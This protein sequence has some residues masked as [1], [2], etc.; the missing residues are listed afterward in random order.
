MKKSEPSTYLRTLFDSVILIDIVNRY[1]IRNSVALTNLAQLLI[2]SVA[3]RFTSRSLE[4]SLNN[5]ISFLTIQKYLTHLHEAYLLFELQAFSF[6]T[7]QRIASE[8][9]IY[10]ID[11]GFL[12]FNAQTVA[13]NDSTLLE[14][15]IFIELIRRGYILNKSI[16]Y[17][18]TKG[19]FEVDFFLPNTLEG[20]ELLQVSHTLASSS[21]LER[22]LRSLCKGA[23]E[24]NASKLTIIT[25]NDEA[26][27]KKEGFEIIAIPAWKWC[28]K[29]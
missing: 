8:R 15:I 29:G 21:T 20:G 10:T 26:V 18:Q 7:K 11:N 23:E 2:N 17:L 22:E 6:K 1:K 25:F 5:S 3:S 13:G 9:K 14:N 19:G 28:L 27:Y 16:F 24:V 12:S 4:R